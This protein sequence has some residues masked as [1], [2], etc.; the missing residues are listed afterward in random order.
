MVEQTRRPTHVV[1]I[2][3]GP[4]EVDTGIPFDVN[5][6]ISNR[7]A[8]AFGRQLAVIGDQMD[9]EWAI[10]E[11]YWPLAPIHLL[12]PAQTLTRTIYRDIHSQLWGFQ[13]LFTAVK[14]W[15]VSTSPWQGILRTESLTTWVANVEP[16]PCSGWTRGAL[17]TVALVAAVSIFGALWMEGEA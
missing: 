14:A 11:P 3:A 7:A 1:S 12:R 4:G 8:Q 13:G 16:A 15:I 2:Q 9:R 17:V 10:R 6:R 5:L